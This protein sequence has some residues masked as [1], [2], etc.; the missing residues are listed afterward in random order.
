LRGPL[1]HRENQAV[2]HHPGSQKYP[3]EFEHAFVGHPC[4]N[5]GHEAVVIDSIEEFLEVEVNDD[6]V[7]FGDITL[8]LSYRLMGR[9][10]RTESVTVLGKRRV[11]LL[12]Q[13]L[14]HGLL[15]QSVDDTRHA[16]FSDPTVRL[17]Y[18][19]PLD[20]LWLVGSVE[21]LGPY[22]WPVLTQVVLGGVDSHPIHARTA[23]ISLNAFPRPLKILSV[24]HL[25]HE[26][27]RHSRAFGCW[28][29]HEWFG[30][31]RSDGRGFTPSARF[32]G[33]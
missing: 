27:F 18:F 10:P 21:Q 24:A 30:P 3:D 13:N 28:L 22:A 19:D 6:I 8:C 29:R 17:G 31:R 7:A 25:L 14:Q 32:Q 26:L 9:A 2:L 33:Q 5:A 23:L 15:D 12:L 20:R 16:E 11:P 4:G 1:I